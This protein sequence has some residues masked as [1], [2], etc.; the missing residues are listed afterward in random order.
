MALNAR[1]LSNPTRPGNKLLA[2][3]PEEDYRRVA[4]LFDTVT[5][6]DN[7]M[8][9]ISGTPLQ[10]VYFPSGGVCSL[11]CM[12][13]DG[14]MADAAIVGN[15]GVVG[16]N[17]LLHGRVALHE[18]LVRIPGD[19]R[20]LPV[21]TVWREIDRGGAFCD[22]MMRYA[23]VFLEILAQSAGCNAL[24]PVEQRCARR[25]LDIHD[26]MG[27]EGF[28][29]TQELLATMLGVRRASITGCISEFHRSGL[30]ELGRRRIVVGDRPGLE[31]IACECYAT[32]N[33]YVAR[34]LP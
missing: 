32:L 34:L 11:T 31:R 7:R 24:H 4:P 5:L 18:V 30:I 28:P 9:Q 16:L 22:V 2:R 1:H 33:A 21:K 13:S 29:L 15:E 8:L 17:A 3:L 27:H 26:R 25:L 23:Q 12:M 20:T 6:T 10:R 14:H 19:A